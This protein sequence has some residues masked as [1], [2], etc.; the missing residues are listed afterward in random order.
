[1]LFSMKRARP[2]IFYRQGCP[3]SAKVLEYLESRKVPYQAVEV[4]DNEASFHQLE[5]ATGQT[6]T[7]A[8]VH[9][10]E[11]LHNFDLPQLAS[12]LEKHQLDSKH[13]AA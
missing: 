6:K 13:S 3:R 9:G 1:M 7:P 8:L 4:K 2:V 11:H 12:F 5:R 10:H